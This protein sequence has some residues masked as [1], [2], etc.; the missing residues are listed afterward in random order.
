MAK[1][2]VDDP[3]GHYIE[4]N[5]LRGIAILGVVIVHSSNNWLNFVQVP[6]TVPLLEFADFGGYG[7][8]LFFLLSGYLLTWKEEKRKRSGIYSLRSYF[9]RR[10]CRLVPA[11][12]VAIAVTVIFWSND[13]DV[14]A[15]LIHISFLHGFPPGYVDTLEP[16]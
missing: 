6:L 3:R 7:V 10:V 2:P 11:Y 5:A 4:L 8:T 15:V 16:A 14:I 1:K 12:F 9:L 13:N